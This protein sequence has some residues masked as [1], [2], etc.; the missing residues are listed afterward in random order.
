MDTLTAVEQTNVQSYFVTLVESETI[1]E[2]SLEPAPQPCNKA[3]YACVDCNRSFDN[4]RQL[5]KHKRQHVL[6]KGGYFKFKRSVCHVY[7]GADLSVYAL[8]HI[9]QRDCESPAISA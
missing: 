8:R 7:V 2:R 3:L 6:N 4:R 5:D 9:L 1:E